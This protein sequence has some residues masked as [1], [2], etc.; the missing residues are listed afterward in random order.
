MFCVEFV[1]V[2]VLEVL[3]TQRLRFYL[4]QSTVMIGLGAVR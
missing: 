2:A 1:M 3:Q 4:S